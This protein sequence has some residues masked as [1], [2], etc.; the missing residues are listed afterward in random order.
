MAHYRSF[1][2]SFFS[3]DLC[4]RTSQYRNF[5][6]TRYS[7]GEKKC[8]YVKSFWIWIENTVS[9]ISFV[10]KAE[11]RLSRSTLLKTKAPEAI[12]WSI[13]PKK[14]LRG[15]FRSKF[16][17]KQLLSSFSISFFQKTNEIFKLQFSTE[18]QVLNSKK[19]DFCKYVYR[20]IL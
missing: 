14:S 2:V 17:K 5:V 3:C 10:Q 6:G 12:S 9:E 1:L 8:I 18:N 4:D 7:D 16:L 11:T 15:V 19:T 13:S 20:R